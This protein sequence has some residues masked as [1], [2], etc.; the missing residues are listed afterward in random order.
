[1]K[2]SKSKDKNKTD[3]LT[4]YEK[5]KILKRLIKYTKGNQKKI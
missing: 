2:I 5:D 3:D 1:M 4:E